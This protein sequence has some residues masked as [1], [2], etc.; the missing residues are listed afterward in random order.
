M[1][2]ACL[3][4]SYLVPVGRIP[5]RSSLLRP[6]PFAQVV[7]R[8]LIATLLL[9][10]TQSLPL[11]SNIFSSLYAQQWRCQHVRRS[12]LGP[13]L[14]SQSESSCMCVVERHRSHELTASDA[15]AESHSILPDDD[16][17]EGDFERVIRLVLKRQK[18]RAQHKKLDKRR[19]MQATRELCSSCRP[20]VHGS[21]RLHSPSSSSDSTTSETKRAN[22]HKYRWKQ[23]TS[24]SI[25]DNP[26]A[27]KT[28]PLK[29][30]F[31]LDLKGAKNDL[32]SQPRD[33]SQP[34]NVLVPDREIGVRVSKDNSF[35]LP[36]SSEFQRLYIR[37]LVTPIEAR[38][39]EEACRGSF[40]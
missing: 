13:P 22:R 6:H 1:F 35:P 7:S 3:S 40:L 14:Q 19:F 25:P 12:H 24:L 39:F 28:L 10:S 38:R 37:Y 16:R 32:I 34:F 20:S 4:Q 31:L 9:T 26:S 30:N 8:S 23:R 27:A 21:K 11:S 29:P 33:A 36:S 18:A 15:E 17:S 5:P 2:V